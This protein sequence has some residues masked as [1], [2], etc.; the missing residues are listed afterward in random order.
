MLRLYDQ[1][2][3][4]LGTI[5]HVRD[6]C[7]ESQMASGDKTLSCVVLEAPAEIKAEYYIRN[8]VDEFVVKEVNRD[9]SGY[10]SIVCALNLEELEAKAWKTFNAANTTIKAATELAIAGTGWTVASS[11]VTKKRNAGIIKKSALGVI[12]DLCTAFMCEVSYDTINKTISF[13]AKK[14]QDR[15]VYF[16]TG[17]NLRQLS[18]NTRSYDFYTRI[19]PYGADDL[20]IKAVNN[21]REY[22]ENYQYSNKVRTYIWIDTNYTDA[23]ALKEDAIAKLAD[24]SKPEKAYSA[25]IRDLAAM[26]DTYTLLSYGIGDTITLIDENT[27][28]REKQRIVKLTEYPDE[29]ERNTCELSN[30]RLTWEEM[31]SQLAASAAIV[32]ALIAT[33]GQYNG[34]IKVSDILH[35][36]DGVVGSSGGSDVTLGN[37]YQTTSGT[38]GAL[39]LEV[40]TLTAT[41]A[42]ITFANI[43]TANITTA[44]VKD[45]FVQVGLIK[46]AVIS[47]AKIT[48]YLDAVEVNAANITAGTLVADRIAIRGSNTSLVYA[49]NNYGQ[50]SSTQV[51]TLD[52]YVLTPRTINADKIV[53]G[54]ITG[55]E[56]AANTITANKLSVLTL[57]AITADVGTVTAGVL[58]SADFV[59]PSDTTNNPYSATGMRVDLTNKRIRAVNFAV[60]PSGQLYA[61]GGSVG[62][63]NISSTQLRSDVT[64][65]GVT[66]SAVTQAM[67]TSTDTTRGAFYIVRNENGT[68]TNPF[69]VQ[70]NGK[71]TAIDA[72]ITGTITANGGSIGGFDIS[73]TQLRSDVTVSGTTYSAVINKGTASDDFAFYTVT[74]SGAATNPFYVRYDGYMRAT[75]ANI[76]GTITANGGSI[77]GFDISD[78]QLRSDKTVS[79]ITYSAV[80]QAMG[81][82]TDTTRAAFYIAK[83][84]NGTVTN[85]FIVRY[86]GDLIST[87]G[88]IGG[89]DISATQ[90]RSDV[91]VSGT[92]YSAVIQKGS[93]SG[94]YAFYTATKVGDAA[95]T[96]PFYVRYDGYIRAT[97][98]KIGPLNIQ[99]E[100]VYTDTATGWR[101][102]A[103]VR[104]GTN[105]TYPEIA[106]VSSSEDRVAIV[107]P[108]G[109]QIGKVTTG[110]AIASLNSTSLMITADSKVYDQYPRTEIYKGYMEMVGAQNPIRISHYM[111]RGDSAEQSDAYRNILFTSNTFGTG[112]DEIFGAIQSVVYTTGTTAMMM[113]T[114]KNASGTDSAYIGV[115]YPTSNSSYVQTN[116]DIRFSATSKGLYMTG[117]DGLFAAIYD[118]GSNLWIGAAGS[119]SRHHSGTTGYTYISTGWNNNNNTY[120]STI[121]L[122]RPSAKAT[123]GGSSIQVATSSSDI[124]LKTNISQ[125]EAKGLPLINAIKMKSF[126][127]T[128]NHEYTH[129]PIG[130]IA[131]EIEKLDPRLAIGGGSDQNGNMCI[132]QV[133]TFYLVGY[134]VKAVQ[135]LS[136]KI[137]EL[138][139]MKAA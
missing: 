3:T 88:N 21:N 15:G 19:I 95:A 45:L 5:I 130:M 106:T 123:G 81:N 117:V 43:D 79:G 115:F 135:E 54:T 37:F 12:N 41:K 24:M 94:T 113:R 44:K 53:A 72:N 30:T 121:Y 109:F 119:N 97:S 125:C 60:T 67:G 98:G 10:P 120:N 70:Y 69:L 46:D 27:G 29:P 28:T 8:D 2:H 100:A 14:G 136:A 114:Y 118:N 9:T 65:S 7:I 128:D 131:D 134:L 127:W 58:Q 137:K 1:N 107:H 116:T 25:D 50:I 47:G 87:S 89:F 126:D 86:N 56:I 93:G 48:G 22:V 51:N 32:D 4:L 96:N 99:S 49:L 92:K 85:P 11:T 82:S 71:L 68:I 40:G 31:Q 122:W 73:S 76:T 132:K 101:T 124:R 78:Y 103:G 102:G 108:S 110:Q 34:T 133:D 18:I 13:V 111:R 138:E 104:I 75:N 129:Q 74:N 90:L 59:L 61:K 36:E 20:D 35:F 62:G 23:T 26:S 38:L 105:T 139:R 83:N 39:E 55:N 77:G 66:Y 112:S 91:T 52:G 84:N 16:L 33:D 64:A 57:S 42:D 80:M 17:L 6:Y 63:F